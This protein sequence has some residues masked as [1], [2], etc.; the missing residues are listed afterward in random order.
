MFPAQWRVQS[1]RAHRGI[2]KPPSAR[3]VD[4]CVVD[5][6]CCVVDRLANQNLRLARHAGVVCHRGLRG[7]VHVMQLCGFCAARDHVVER[8]HGSGRQ[9]LAAA[10]D[11]TD[12]TLCFYVSQG[13]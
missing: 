7:A 9:R 8:D 13:V 10:D 3:C 5:A 12:A 2:R 6:H 4:R 1:L 11:V